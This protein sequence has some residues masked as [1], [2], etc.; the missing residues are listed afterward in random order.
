[1]EQLVG[2]MSSQCFYQESHGKAKKYVLRGA[3]NL[4]A[5]RR[6]YSLSGGPD[7]TRSHACRSEN[8]RIILN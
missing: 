2:I 5:E 7:V 6:L 4:Q 3:I 8:V 1:M